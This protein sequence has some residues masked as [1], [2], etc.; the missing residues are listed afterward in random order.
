MGMTPDQLLAQR[1]LDLRNTDR[2]VQRRLESEFKAYIAK[3][4]DENFKVATQQVMYAS[5]R[6]FF[7]IHYCPLMMRRGDYPKG[8][9]DGVKRATKDAILKVLAHKTRNSFTTHPLI[10]FI[11]DTGLRISDVVAL[12]CGDILRQINNGIC[13]IQIN[14]VT[15]KTNLLAKT[16]IGEEAIQALKTY[17]EIRRAGS[18]W[19][20]EIIPEEISENSPLFRSW[21]RGEVKPMNRISASHLVANAFINIGEKRMSAHSLRK[22]LQTDLEKAG[23]NSNW[24]DQILGH[25]LINSRDAYSLP[26]DEELK[27]AYEKGYQFIRVHSEKDGQKPIIP[28]KT[29]E[30]SK[31]GIP[32]IMENQQFTVRTATT[33]EQSILLI[34]QGFTYADTIDGTRIYKK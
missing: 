31:M 34:S 18:K 32:Q 26:T 29:T 15:E 2:K 19:Q 7:E 33:L 17:F 9:S 3:K 25:Q 21:T 4:R 27:E 12:K 8:D 30:D 11:K 28:P 23:I 10:L 22:K 14:I 1:E 5:I 16:F 20:K 6:S 13:P 24:I